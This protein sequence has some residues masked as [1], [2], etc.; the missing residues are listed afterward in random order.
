MLNITKIFK[1]NE[2]EFLKFENCTEKVCERAD[3][4]AWAILDRL[5]PGDDDMVSSAEH[6]EIFLVVEPNE[7]ADIATEEDIINLI[8]CGVRLDTQF[9]C[10]A[11]F[12]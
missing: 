7:I 2:D 3:L 12:V 10:F 1:D 8:R 4:C 6:D 11:M 5:V 9:D